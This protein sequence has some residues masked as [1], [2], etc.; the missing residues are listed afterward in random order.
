MSTAGPAPA[1]ARE[2]LTSEGDVSQLRSP[3]RVGEG[4][5]SRTKISPPGTPTLTPDAT[6]RTNAPATPFGASDG[7]H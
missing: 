5:T 2:A 7:G 1:E 3:V 6:R 4:D